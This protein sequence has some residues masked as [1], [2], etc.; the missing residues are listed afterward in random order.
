MQFD[1]PEAVERFEKALDKF[2]DRYGIPQ[3][4]HRR[5]CKKGKDNG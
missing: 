4:A 2:R 1:S 5:K 3:P